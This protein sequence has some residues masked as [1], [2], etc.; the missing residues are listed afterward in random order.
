VQ[1]NKAA[2]TKKAHLFVDQKA[3]HRR[4]RKRFGPAGCGNII[5]KARRTKSFLV[6][7]FKKELLP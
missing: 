4:K 6:L 5:A 3:R 1:G 2:R 7:F